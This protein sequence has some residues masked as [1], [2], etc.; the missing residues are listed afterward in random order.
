VTGDR[1][2]ALQQEGADLIDNSGTLA[3]EPLP[4]PVQRL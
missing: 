4:Y 1:D 3:D 2:A